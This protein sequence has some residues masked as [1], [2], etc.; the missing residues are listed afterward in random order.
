MLCKKTL[1]EAQI[2]YMTIEKELLVVVYA[3]KKFRPYILGSDNMQKRAS[4]DAHLC[5]NVVKRVKIIYIFHM[6]SY[7][8]AKMNNY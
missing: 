8:Y 2:K 6:L 1:D 5:H 4:K 7:D 3:L